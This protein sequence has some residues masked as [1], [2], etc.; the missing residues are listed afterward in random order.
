MP[1]IQPHKK[2]VFCVMGV[3][4]FHWWLFLNSTTAKTML[5][6]LVTAQAVFLYSPCRK[7]KGK[8]AKTGAMIVWSL[9]GCYI[10]YSQ[11][12]ASWVG[13]MAGITTLA[14]LNGPLR[15]KKWRLP[16][17][18]GLAAMVLALAL[19]HKT[20]SS[21]GRMLIYKVIANGVA[22]RDLVYG[23][24][25]GKFKAVYNNWQAKYFEQHDI[26][27]KEA[28]LADNTYYAFNDYLQLILEWGV[29]GMAILLLL[30]II[31]VFL[32]KQLKGTTQSSIAKGAMAS[33]MAMLTAA[34][35]SYPLQNTPLQVYVLLCLL[36]AINN[37]ANNNRLTIQAIN[38][39][40][41]FVSIM[42]CAREIKAQKQEHAKEQAM[43]LS[44][45]G[46][47]NKAM[48]E[49]EKLVSNGYREGNVLYLF[50]R[51]LYYA[52]QTEKA[53]ESLNQSSQY[54]SNSETVQLFAQLHEERGEMGKAEYYYQQQVY[55]IPNRF[56]SRFNLMQFHLRQNNRRLAKRCA[57]S[58]ASLPV[59]IPSAKVERIREAAANIGRTLW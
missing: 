59:K 12:R 46:Y 40:G 44:R 6:M 19:L 30:G 56:E 14:C 8:W 28:L 48:A 9:C 43:T 3:A 53:L 15:Q 51:E 55:M 31:I 52:N 50:A 47:R 25:N 5:P 10:V 17:L 18:A 38:C 4:W 20:G 29:A 36:M 45:T 34:L 13:L 54:I 16:I 33:A 23:V 21:Q 37:A 35:F 27:S 58:I 2:T 41:L 32:F 22:T 1:F 42:L 24:G 39:I 57:A 11:S 26:N 7:I 49:L